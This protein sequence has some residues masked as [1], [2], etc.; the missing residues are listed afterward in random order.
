MEDE[1]ESLED[2]EKDVYLEVGD[3]CLTKGVSL[4]SFFFLEDELGH[5]LG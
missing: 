2:R 1:V 5:A 4:F 3:F